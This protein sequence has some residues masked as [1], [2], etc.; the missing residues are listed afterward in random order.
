MDIEP[1]PAA[2]TPRVR[3]AEI[4]GFAA[5]Y[6]A[7][8]TAG[9]TVNLTL[10]HGEAFGARVRALAVMV[11]CGS[12]LGG[13]AARLVAVALA[14]RTAGLRLP[15][16]IVMFAAATFCGIAFAVGAERYLFGETFDAVFPSLHWIFERAGIFA[17][18]AFLLALGA[19]HLFVPIPILLAAAAGVWPTRRSRQKR[20][21]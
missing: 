10:V 12:F 14:R 4:A 3:L 21:G 18:S 17:G 6:S 15:V 9:V 7:V 11:A 5:G 13:I 16:A 1:S 2:A 8:L 20:P 19:P